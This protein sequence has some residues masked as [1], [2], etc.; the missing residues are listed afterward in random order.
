MRVI[1]LT[2]LGKQCRRLDVLVR[3]WPLRG[4]WNNEMEKKT[5]KIFF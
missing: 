4:I 3:I 2:V 1:D 5:L